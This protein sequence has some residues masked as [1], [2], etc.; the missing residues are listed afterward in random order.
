MH[1]DYEKSTVSLEPLRLLKRRI[2][3]WALTAGLLATL[4]GW[5]PKA[6]AGLLT[7]YEQV[8]FPVITLLCLGSLITLW[9]TLRALVWVEWSLF[10][11]ACIS[12]LGRLEEI[13]RSPTTPLAP[14]HLAAFSD[15]LY[16]FPL[17]YVLAF[18]IFDSH[19]GLLIGSLTFFM[20]AVAVGLVHT[21][22][23]LL[24]GDM[25]DF[26][27]LGRF[28]LANATYI[29]LLMVSVRMNEQYIRVHTWAETMTHLASTD[30][31]M[32]I[33]NRRELNVTMAREINRTTRHSQPLSAVLFDLDNFKLVNDTYGH[34]A[35]D[36]V[37][38]ETA[39]LAQA[40]LRISD[41]LG[42]WGG[43]EF[44]VIAPHTD[45][46]H[47]HGLAERLRRAIET[48]SYQHVGN[49]TASFGVA[50]YHPG[51]SPEAWLK[52]ADEAL[53]T[54]KQGGRNRV[55]TE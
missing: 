16:W 40:T 22:P 17:V 1:P 33:S 46:I 51:A 6:F 53:Y 12:M 35:G 23:Q 37:L 31:L 5:I 24:Q 55:V 43:E 3:L 45:A 26:Y 25:V 32:Q 29:L 48:Y 27:V 9:Q 42:R 47:A 2:Y 18:L 19:R 21:I 15:L 39:I 8:I 54:A 28:Y 49:I 36:T 52:C 38:Q 20:A 7:S 10:V 13:L 34:Q 14:N 41:F 4:L 11:I 30:A 50:Q 44:L